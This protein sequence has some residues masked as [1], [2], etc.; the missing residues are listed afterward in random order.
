MTDT[1]APDRAHDELVLE[2]RA[3]LDR[4]ATNLTLLIGAHD[5]GTSLIGCGLNVLASTYGRAA[6]VAFLRGCANDLEADRTPC[7]GRA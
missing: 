6:A 4:Q 2:A 5:T 3:R 7:E 1:T